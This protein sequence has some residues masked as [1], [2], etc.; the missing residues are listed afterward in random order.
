MSAPMITKV[1]TAGAAMAMILTAATARAQSNPLEH[2]A[3]QYGVS[4]QPLSSGTTGGKMDFKPYSASYLPRYE[5]PLNRQ[6]DTGID[7]VIKNGYKNPD[8]SNCDLIHD[9]IKANV[10]KSS[11]H[12]FDTAATN[13]EGTNPGL[14]DDYEKNGHDEHAPSWT[15]FCHLWAPAGLDPVSNFIVSM[16]RIYADVPFGI[17]DLK[18]LNTWNYPHPSSK[19]FGERN[20]GD[21]KPE[22]NF[23]PADMLAIFQNY[24][25]SGKPGVVLDVTPGAEVWNQAVYSYENVATDATADDAKA[26]GL[27]IPAGG[28]AIKANLSMTWTVEGSY[29]YRG[30]A[31]T[32]D[33]TLAYTAVVDKSGKITGAKWDAGSI[34]EVPDF[35]WVPETKWETENY[36]RLQKIAKE[37]IPLSGV[38]KLCADLASLPQGSVP[39]ATAADITA[40]LDVVCPLLDSNKL[41]AYIKDIAAKK[42]IDYSVLDAAINGG[43]PEPRS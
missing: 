8:G 31:Y 13:A 1:M 41:D 33:R 7:D 18:E 15:G 42:G 30:E 9:R 21:E 23:D 12:K 6:H 32:R 5:G 25:G 36:K 40:Q 22:N 26:A 14:A 3:S 43:Q 10:D 19:F 29:A 11:A 17:G 16:D 27:T 38:E 24:V 4:A 35:A 20:N 39:A 2:W 34:G 37:G 28:K